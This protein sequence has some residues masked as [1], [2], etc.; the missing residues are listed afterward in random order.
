LFVGIHWVRRRKHATVFEIN[1][2]G[3]QPKELLIRPDL[4]T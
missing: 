2:S 4:P 1:A 3:Y